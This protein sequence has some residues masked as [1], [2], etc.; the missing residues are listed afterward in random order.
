MNAE[1][2]MTRE[3]KTVGPGESIHAA[4]SL[5]RSEH[6][7]HVLVTKDEKLVGVLS[8]RDCANLMELSPPETKIQELFQLTVEQIMT[9][10]SRVITVS[11]ETPIRRVSELFVTHKIGCVPV[12]DAEQRVVGILSQKDLIWVLLRSLEA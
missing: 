4:L 9:P 8:N 6:I 5:M 11:P 10:A 2:Q 12:V 1:D 7:R 3:V